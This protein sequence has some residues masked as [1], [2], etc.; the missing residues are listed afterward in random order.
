MAG[1]LQ[2]HAADHSP[3]RARVEVSAGEWIAK[4]TILKIKSERLTDSDKLRNVRAEFAAL[5]TVCH[6]DFTESPLMAKLAAD[7]KGPLGLPR[8]RP[9]CAAE[10]GGQRT[11][12]L[13]ASGGKVVS[14][15][16][17]RTRMTARP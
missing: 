8:E 2:R 16:R 5:G 1:E 15:L 10:G 7:L 4:L 17:A 6:E 13:Q 14:E 12:R 11:A 3:A 9:A